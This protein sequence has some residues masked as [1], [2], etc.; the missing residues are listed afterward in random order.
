MYIY[1]YTYV[2]MYIYVTHSIRCESHT[3]DMTHSYVILSGTRKY[4][5][6]GK[7]CTRAIFNTETWR[8]GKISKKRVFVSLIEKDQNKK[9]Q[10]GGKNPHPSDLQHSLI[11]D[12][13][14]LNSG[15]CN[16]DC[17]AHCNIH[18]NIH[19]NTFWMSMY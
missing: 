7:I 18:C 1:V 3:N 15:A 13:I 5:R 12:P 4:R 10:G 6:D 8:V 2:Y 11:T 9:L 19:C 17:D 16:I 14:A